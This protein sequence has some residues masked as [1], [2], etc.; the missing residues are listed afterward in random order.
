MWLG[1]S[2]YGCLDMAGNVW[3]WVEVADDGDQRVGLGRGVIAV[4]GVLEPLL[5][6]ALAAIRWSGGTETLRRAGNHTM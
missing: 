5:E 4:R 1:A 3:E 2:P 6:P